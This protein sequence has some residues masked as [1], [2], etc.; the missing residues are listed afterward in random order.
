MTVCGTLVFGTV[1]LSVV[2]LGSSVVRAPVLDD[3][4][5]D[6]AGVVT[7][8]WRY[9]VSAIQPAALQFQACADGRP[10]GEVS[11][12]VMSWHVCWASLGL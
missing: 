9:T 1:M 12:M 11:K 8:S 10:Y 3:E 2:R 7:G 6:E 4:V 5:E